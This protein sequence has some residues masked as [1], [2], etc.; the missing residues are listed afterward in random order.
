MIFVFLCPTYF[1]Q[2]TYPLVTSMLL[3][4]ARFHSFLCLTFHCVYI[5]RIFIHSSSDGLLGCFRILAIVNNPAVIHISFL[6]FFF[7]RRAARLV[8]SQF[9]DQ[10]SNPCPLQWK[11]GVLTTGPPGNSLHIS[12][13]FSKKHIKL[14]YLQ[15]HCFRCTFMDYP[16][17]VFF[18]AILEILNTLSN[19]RRSSCQVPHLGHPQVIYVL[20]DSKQSAS[21]S[22]C[23]KHPSFTDNVVEARPGR[24]LPRVQ[25]PGASDPARPRRQP[26]QTQG[27]RALLPCA[28]AVEGQAATG[29]GPSEPPPPYRPREP[30][31]IF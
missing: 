12:F 10:G 7:F 2:H 27:G 30:A 8:G 18:L 11:H 29:P 15:P 16:K 19:S 20:P 14:F 1:T 4:M 28:P 23:F 13:F 21:S 22:L 3:Q 17:A 6:P 24:C 25:G 31:H 26:H 5:H 9:P